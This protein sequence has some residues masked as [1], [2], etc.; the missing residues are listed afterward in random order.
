MIK[1]KEKNNCCGC[2]SCY[3]ICP[4]KAIE[5]VEDEKGFKYP[6]VDKEK[7]IDCGLCEK[8]CPIIANLKVENKPKAYACINVDEN[9]RMQSSSGG[10]F[11]AIASYI[12]DKGG[13]VFGASWNEDFS[14]VEHTYTDKKE[15]LYKFRGA[16]YL[17]SDIDNSYIKVKQFL[18][19]GRYVLFSGTPCQIE[20]L[21]LFLNKEYDKL[22]L[23]DII[24]HGVPSPK[25]W[26]K[27]KEYIENNN[28]ESVVNNMYFRDKT[29]EGW[30]KYHVK[31][32]FENGKDYDVEHGKDIYMKAF[33]SNISLRDS[34]T[35]CK[36][37]KENRVSDITLADFWGINN[38]K[39]EMN[40]E[41]GTSLVIVNSEKGKLLFEQISNTI[42]SEE[43]DFYTAIKPNPSMNTISPKNA[44]NE[45]FFDN[46][47]RV[48]FDELVKKYVPEPSVFKK[49]LRKV[50]RIVKKVI[51][52]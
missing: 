43:V 41:K 37:K 9:I 4:K 5:M 30:N 35:S 31:M 22:Y 49:A 28:A 40:D 24:C 15:E 23:Q 39:P 51:K 45:E 21:K 29:A 19:E 48:T 13:V 50:K 11:T 18:E 3:N 16:K 14:R 2:Y 17:Q 7:C 52:K 1:I 8:V 27:Y 34:C 33:L 44:K 20:G 32:Q 46:L 6:K 42:K 10:V 47:D 38:I 12:I 26:K 25:S 36:F